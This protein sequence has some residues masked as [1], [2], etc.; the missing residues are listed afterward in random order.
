MLAFYVEWHQ[1]F[2]RHVLKDL[3]Y[4]L[5]VRIDALFAQVLEEISLAQFAPPAAK[6]AHLGI[7]IGKNDTLK[8]MLYAL[9]ELKGINEQK[10]L[11]LSVKA[12]EIGRMLYGWKVSAEKRTAE[13]VAGAAD[14]RRRP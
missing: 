5:G 10:F 4:S 8:F 9:Y 6:P 13:R 7:A 14:A 11:S 1:I 3:R 12:E 2:S